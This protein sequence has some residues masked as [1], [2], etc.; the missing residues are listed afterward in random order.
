MRRNLRVT[1][2]LEKFWVVTV[3]IISELMKVWFVKVS[4]YANDL[5]STLPGRSRAAAGWFDDWYRKG[6]LR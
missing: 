1:R 2:F 3:R 6:S 5:C 4:G